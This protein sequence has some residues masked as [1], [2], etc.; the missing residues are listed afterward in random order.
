MSILPVEALHHLSAMSSHERGRSDLPGAYTLVCTGFLQH[1][2]GV[3]GPTQNQIKDG[4]L[5]RDGRIKQ[6]RSKKSARAEES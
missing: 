4:Q 6:C 1:C 5:L 3:A 2:R